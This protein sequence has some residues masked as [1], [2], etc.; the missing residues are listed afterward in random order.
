[1]KIPVETE[2]EISAE[3]FV[4]K[5]Q[6]DDIGKILSAVAEKFDDDFVSRTYCATQFEEGLSE[7]GA[8]F[9]AEI[10]T[11]RFAKKK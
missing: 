11:Q 2:I 9:V 8:R 4:R 6:P 1:M 7:G 5:L 10:I 3:D